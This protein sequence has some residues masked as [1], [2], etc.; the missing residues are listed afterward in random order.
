MFH[1]RLEHISPDLNM[2]GKR[3]CEA[4]V[5]VVEEKSF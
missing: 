2:V 1:P 4:F 3:F 5:I